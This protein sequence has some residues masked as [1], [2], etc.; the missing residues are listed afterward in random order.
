MV[1]VLLRTV[2]TPQSTIG[3]LY[4]NGK[5]ECYTLEDRVREAKIARH[6]AIP[7]GH[8]PVDITYSPRFKR[9]LPLI[10]NVPDFVGIRIHPGNTA[11]DT[12]GCILVGRGI[13]PDFITE[14]K[15]AF[16][17]L[18]AKLQT[19]KATSLTIIEYRA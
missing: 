2:F 7:A 13:K 4:V 8:Y 1:L 12:E 6:T 16:D 3:N 19:S 9:D 18:F 10:E 14:S 5:F 15:L 17:A 11:D